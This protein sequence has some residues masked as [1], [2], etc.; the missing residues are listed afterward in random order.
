M[1]GKI[2]KQRGNIVANAAHFTAVGP[3]RT[4]IVFSVCSLYPGIPTHRYPNTS[5]FF[6][7]VI[8]I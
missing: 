7:A 8:H 5:G 3:M 6:I 1:P 4:G 2:S